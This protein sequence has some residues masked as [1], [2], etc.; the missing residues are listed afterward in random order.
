MAD[1]RVLCVGNVILGSTPQECGERGLLYGKGAALSRWIGR[2][3][4][5]A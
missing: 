5:K 2:A 3:R 4:A 1:A